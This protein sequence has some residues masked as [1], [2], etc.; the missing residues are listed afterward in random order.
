MLWSEV[1]ERGMMVLQK[2]AAEYW[3]SLVLLGMD[4]WRWTA[5]RVGDMGIL[6]QGGTTRLGRRGWGREL[7]NRILVG[8]P[9]MGRC[10]YTGGY[11][12]QCIEP[13]VEWSRS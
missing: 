4:H 10:G 8:D 5:A 9:D 7:H 12:Q 1:R 6:L 11:L 13:C 2:V 3:G